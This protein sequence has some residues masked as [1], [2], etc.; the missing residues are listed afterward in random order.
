MCG[1]VGVVDLGGRP[2]SGANLPAMV[3]ALA[4]R[5]PDDAG[6]L[7]W[8]SRR[9]DPR[10]R[11]DP[12]SL[13]TR[14]FH[15]IS[16]ELP[17][18]EA[19]E[20]L[21]QLHE[22][23][24]DV[25]LGHRRL[26]VQ[27]LSPR[28]HQP[29][30][31]P[32]GRHWIVYNGEIYNFR[33]LR[34][35]LEKL[36]HA[37]VS[38][39]DTEVV[40]HAYAEWGIDCVERLNGMFA[41]ALLDCEA[42][43]LHF[44]RDRYGIKPLY[45][46]WGEGRLAFASEQKAL[47]AGSEVRP[48][49]D[50]LAVNEYFSFQNVFS[51]R[52]LLRDVHILPAGH[53]LTLSLESGSSETRRYW[54]FDFTPDETLGLEEVEEQVS[55][56][57]EQAVTRQCVSDVPIGTYLSG[58]MDSGSVSAFT[59]RNLGRIFS[60]TVGFD[61][62]EAAPHELTFDERARAEILSNHLQTEHYECVLHSGDMEA[63]LDEIVWSLE[64][65]RLGQ[66]YPN[67]YVARL[68]SKFV[69]V[70]MMGAGGDELFAGYPWRYAA[71]VSSEQG[72]FV[73]NYYRY[74]QRLVSNREKRGLFNVATQ[75]RLA[76][77]DD[78]GARPFVDH[79][80]KA[81]ERVLGAGRRGDSRDEQ[82]RNAL[83]FE[84]KTFLHGLLVVDDKLTM[85]HSLEARVPFLDNDLVDFAMKIPTRFNLHGVEGIQRMDENLPRKKRYYGANAPLGKRAL[86]SSMERHLPRSFLDAPK[87]GFSAPDESW[88][89]GRSAPYIEETL[90]DSGSPIYA[91]FDPAYVRGEVEAHWRGDRNR[92][93][94]IW[95]LLCFD[96][97]MRI[98]DPVV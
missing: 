90:L 34:E 24:F 63:A 4:H 75:E 19:E 42:N 8:R 78:H 55:F 44:A 98:F 50:L 27:D 11:R 26:S 94:L 6:L 86:R 47:L 46:Q 52:T 61:L 9:L 69:K 64:D 66:S 17:V 97:W 33:E 65:L 53:V 91:L 76:S 80:L 35:T 5:G 59:A 10:G 36:G 23:R 22:E 21:R 81:F 1:I 41:F 29:M 45:L 73:E 62:S 71:A 68:A 57:V 56:L 20:G 16:P 43:V 93:L 12:L 51:D 38:S 95:S 89:R 87:Q 74:W 54:D 96:R 92:R 39:G 37:F 72:S 58:G 60:F 70:V 85:A 7:L 49:L 25:F 18:V 40:L 14:E 32:T 88:F 13:T 15:A 3:E 83:Y 79:T 2:L 48:E 67:W 84:C 77:L 31:G 30:A 82:V 28:G